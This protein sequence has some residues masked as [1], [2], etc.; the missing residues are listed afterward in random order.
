MHVGSSVQDIR[1]TDAVTLRG[2]TC[3]HGGDAADGHCD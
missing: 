2:G 1:L 3:A